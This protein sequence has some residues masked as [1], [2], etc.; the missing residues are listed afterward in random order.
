MS[1]ETKGVGIS[2]ASDVTVTELGVF[3]RAVRLDYA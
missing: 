1:G 3:I 2:A